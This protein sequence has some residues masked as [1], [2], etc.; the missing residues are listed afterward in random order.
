[1][2]CNKGLLKA[3]LKIEVR[4]K[5]GKLVAVRKKEIDLILDNFR[6]ILAA[7]LTPQFDFS[8]ITSP[9]VVGA[10][11]YAG[12]VDL[13]GTAR[14]VPTHAIATVGTTD[15]V[16][17]TITCLSGYDYVIKGSIGVTILIGTSTAA[18]TRGDYKLGAQVAWGIPTQTV[19]ADYISWAVSI[20]LETAADIAEAGL[21]I[22][23]NVVAPLTT[24]VMKA[25]LLFRDTFT[26][27]SVPAG[28]TISVTYTLTL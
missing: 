3:Q 11:K 10:A 23:A 13:E 24:R 6:D 9:A 2:S 7:L 15:N 18:P 1:M 21:S 17:M 25:I 20:V 12:I 4:D 8:D 22:F 19:G 26:A 16:G 27:V 14:D 28:G 5:E